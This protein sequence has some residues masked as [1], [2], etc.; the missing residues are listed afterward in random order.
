MEKARN[1]DEQARQEILEYYRDRLQRM[2][3]L[4]MDPR[5][6]PRFAPSDVVQDSMIRAWE[7]LSGYLEDP[8][9]PLYPWLRE[10]TWKRLVELHRAHVK[11]RKR[12]VKCEKAQTWEL[13]D[14]SSVILSRRLMKRE[15]NP[16]SRLIQE[17]QLDRIKTALNALT[18]P[19]QEV[20]MLIYLEGLSNQEIA[21]TLDLSV[22]GVKKRHLRALRQLRSFLIGNKTAGE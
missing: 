7:N 14:N 16:Q 22:A 18:E 21:F 12:S 10:F 20:L 1:G 8:P 17:E 5:L 3:A 2:V 6:A 11:A 9:V 13:P 19:Y 15:R 4:R